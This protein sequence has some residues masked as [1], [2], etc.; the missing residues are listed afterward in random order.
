MAISQEEY[1]LDFWLK[2][3]CPYCGNPIP[4]GTRFGSGR[5]SDGGFCSL[6][7]YTA[8]YQLELM[9]RAKKRAELSE[10]HRRS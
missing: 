7:C 5:K 9:Q 3:I 10:K 2:G 1:L 4:G 8:Y 6:T